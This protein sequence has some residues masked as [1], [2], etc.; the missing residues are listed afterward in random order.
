MDMMS[1]LSGGG[2]IHHMNL[3]KESIEAGYKK[4]IASMKREI[5]STKKENDGMKKEIANL[6]RN[7]SASDKTMKSMQKE[8]ANLK[9]NNTQ[10]NHLSE[11]E[12]DVDVVVEG[13]GVEQ[14]NGG[15]KQSGEY[16]GAPK[17]TKKGLWGVEEGEFRIYHSTYRYGWYIGF[18]GEFDGLA[19]FSI[20]MEYLY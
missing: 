2:L 20:D 7:A 3:M 4:E 14:I 5:D 11:N 17:Y 18:F 16:C 12:D 13:C 15:Y 1:H 6:K 19:G 8:L 10:I 9:A